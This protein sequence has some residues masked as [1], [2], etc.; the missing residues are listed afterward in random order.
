[1]RA[2]SLVTLFMA[3]V[4]VGCS[5]GSASTPADPDDTADWPESIETM[6]AWPHFG[7]PNGVL[8][9]PHWRAPRK[10]GCEVEVRMKR[11]P[12]R[13]FAE[14]EGP[15]SVVVEELGT[16]CKPVGTTISIVDR[17]VDDDYSLLQG[18]CSEGFVLAA[19]PVGTLAELRFATDEA[20]AEMAAL[21]DRLAAGEGETGDIVGTTAR[22]VTAAPDPVFEVLSFEALEGS[23]RLHVAERE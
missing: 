22:L 13:A 1:M 18:S 16:A 20:C 19:A 9:A 6:P 8:T 2:R 15:R 5:G 11:E 23:P 7:V 3:G 17:P 21:R 12:P 10:F 4:F 14:G